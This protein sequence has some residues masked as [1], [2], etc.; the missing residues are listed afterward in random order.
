[1]KLFVPFA[2]AAAL[3]TFMA[4]SAQ[5]SE[6]NNAQMETKPYSAKYEL[7]RRG[8]TRGHASRVLS[9]TEQNTWRYYTES[10][11]SM[12]FLSDHRE[13]DTEFLMR[14]GRVEPL[15]FDYSREGTGSNQYFTVQFDRPN[16]EL[17]SI[18]GD[19]INADWRDDLL[20]ANAVLHQLQVDVAAGGDNWTYQLLDENGNNREYEFARAKTE[21]LQLPYG[22]VEV[23][24]VDR[25]RDTDRR[26]TF[27]WFA[28][29]L[30]YTLVRMQQ[31]RKGREEAMISLTELNFDDE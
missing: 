28:P 27:F 2:A 25:V 13:N 19:E 9:R 6:Q 30:N 23:V 29:E 26:Q 21:I 10:Y 22:E 15:V 31:L 7:S 5:A 24:R 12:L 8:T 3:T 16:K 18:A 11:A 4:G 20:D 14:N 1:M 17:I